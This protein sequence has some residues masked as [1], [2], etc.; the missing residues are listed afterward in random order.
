MSV[1]DVFHFFCA[2]IYVDYYVWDN[3]YN[4]C[5]QCQGVKLG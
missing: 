3:K 1:R 4:V 5:I 2:V